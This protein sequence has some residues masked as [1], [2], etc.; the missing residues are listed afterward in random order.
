MVIKLSMNCDDCPPCGEKC[1]D[2]SNID[3]VR[4]DVFGFLGP[5]ASYVGTFCYQWNKTTEKFDEVDGPHPWE[6]K[7]N[8][9]LCVFSLVNKTDPK[10]YF[11]YEINPTAKTDPCCPEGVKPMVYGGPVDDGC[12]D[13]SPSAQLEC[14]KNCV[15]DSDPPHDFIKFTTKNFHIDCLEYI[16]IWYFKRLPDDNYGPAVPHWYHL[17]NDYESMA[18]GWVAE[19]E[20]VGCKRILVIKDKDDKY[21]FEFDN[22]QADP[23]CEQTDLLDLP[24]TDFCKQSGV[25]PEG[26]IECGH[27]CDQPFIETVGVFNF[28]YDPN[29]TIPEDEIDEC[30]CHNRARSYFAANGEIEAN[31]RRYYLDPYGYSRFYVTYFWFQDEW[32][33]EKITDSDA[34]W[35]APDLPDVT[36]CCEP[37]HIFDLTEG[38]PAKDFGCLTTLSQPRLHC[39]PSGTNCDPTWC[40]DKPAT[41]VWTVQNFNPGPSQ[42]GNLCI[43]GPWDGLKLKSILGPFIC[44]RFNNT[45]ECGEQD[46]GQGGIEP[47][48]FT[49]DFRLDDP[50]D[51]IAFIIEWEDELAGETYHTVYNDPINYPAGVAIDCMDVVVLNFLSDGP[52]PGIGCVWPSTVT[53]VPTPFCPFT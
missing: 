20:T 17:T 28:F 11:T 1:C 9:K 40:T 15:N 26:K 3:I 14:V 27:F 33:V 52:A 42:D 39:G 46:D 12:A 24:D 23:C 19:W 21:R 4:I 6:L 25:Q 29:P 5:C 44:T 47:V 38:L 53:L 45:I 48:S 41:D 35:W 10:Y 32:R 51:G 16:G 34:W 7:L 22:D 36:K 18:P 43:C 2:E 50:T 13:L 30:L 49:V 37:Q 31:G 8:H